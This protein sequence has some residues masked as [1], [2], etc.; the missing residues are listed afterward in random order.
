[1]ASQSLRMGSSLG[2][3]WLV[4]LWLMNGELMVNYDVSLIYVVN[5]GGEAVDH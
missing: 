4:R 3:Y 1:M 2:H 5:D